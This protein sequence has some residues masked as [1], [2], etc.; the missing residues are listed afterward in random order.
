M[1]ATQFG[2]DS[3]FTPWSLVNTVFPSTSIPG[4]TK[5]TEPGERIISLAVMVFSP[6]SVIILTF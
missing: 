6:L 2:N 1:I 4:G 5:G 3:N